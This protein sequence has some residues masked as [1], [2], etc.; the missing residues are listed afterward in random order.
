MEGL[1]L[2]SSAPLPY[3]RLSELALFE[4]AFREAMRINPPVRGIPRT[5]VRDFQFKGYDIPAGTRA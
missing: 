4:M 3:E 1:G 2:P 5:A